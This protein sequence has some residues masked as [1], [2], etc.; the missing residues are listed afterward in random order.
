M[1]IIASCPPPLPRPPR[2]G[3]AGG[4]GEASRH[5][6]HLSMSSPPPVIHSSCHFSSSPPPV[7]N[8][9]MWSVINRHV[10]TIKTRNISTSKGS[11]SSGNPYGPVSYVAA[12]DAATRFYP[13]FHSLI[14]SASLQH[15]YVSP[16]SRSGIRM[17][18]V[19]RT[20]HSSPAS[21][22]CRPTQGV[23]TGGKVS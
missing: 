7:G 9:L 3:T 21:A 20:V 5:R 13:Q 23:V 8:S 11:D 10:I 4:G 22:N 15:R 1:L 2:S 16:H 19:R 12:Q 6:T 14:A 18:R 17:Y